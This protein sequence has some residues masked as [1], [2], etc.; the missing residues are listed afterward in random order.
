MVFTTIG[1]SGVSGVINS[2][3]ISMK[4]TL[5]R[6]R[7]YAEIADECRYLAEDFNN[8]TRQYSIDLRVHDF[9]DVFVNMKDKLIEITGSF[10][11]HTSGGYADHQDYTIQV[12]FGFIEDPIEW[13]DQWEEEQHQKTLDAIQA[14]ID[15]EKQKVASLEAHD[16][17]EYERLKEKYEAL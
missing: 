8:V 6:L 7:F 1:S 11:T 5:N 2:E 13:Q 17:R 12:P 14:K 4:L 3:R 10:T 9:E 15:R 16:R